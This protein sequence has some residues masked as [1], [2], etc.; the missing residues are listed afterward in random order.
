MLLCYDNGIMKIEK[1]IFLDFDGVV[2]TAETRFLTLAPSCVAHLK[3]II[4]ETNAF[5]VVSS[6]WRKH[7]SLAKLKAMF[8][9]FGMFNRIIDVTCVMNEDRC[10]GREIDA[11]LKDPHPMSFEINGFAI[12]DDDSDMEPHMNHLVK[13]NGHKGL[14]EDDAKKCIKTLDIPLSS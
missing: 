6:V 13:I 7:H 1:I 3:H 2:V 4:N 8:E 10:R 9:P 14:T 12:L 5:I 11:W